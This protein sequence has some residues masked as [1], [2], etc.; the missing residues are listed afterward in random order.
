M[1]FPPGNRG[2]GGTQGASL[3]SSGQAVGPGQE[4]VTAEG[5][6]PL[7]QLPSFQLPSARK[8]RR[9]AVGVGGCPEI[10]GEP[11]ATGTEGLR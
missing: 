6:R 10:P 7:I 11:G 9:E 1:G 3:G 8:V 5:I 4:V 2:Y